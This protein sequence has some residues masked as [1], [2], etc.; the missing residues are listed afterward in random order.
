MTT[1]ST[2]TPASAG[3]LI[4]SSARIYGMMAEFETPAQITQAADKVRA[5]GYRFWDCH[6][7]FPVHGL[8]KVM[9]VKR[10]ILPFF[11]LGAGV[12]GAIVGFCLQAF[13]NAASFSVWALVWVT[14]YPFLVSGKPFMSVP[15]WIPIIF[16][17]TILFSALATVGFMFLL[18]GLPRLSHPLLANN[19]FRRATDDR[20][21]IV[22]ES[23]DPKFLR[24]KTEAF[25]RTLGAKHIEVVEDR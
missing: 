21:F 10:T 8:D 17:F 1:I 25:M 9:G 11:V 20:F 18:N 16:E 14:G 5:A 13:A 15:A 4:D 7:P 6:V 12:T 2:K 24:S 23:R 3:P 22:I 19:R